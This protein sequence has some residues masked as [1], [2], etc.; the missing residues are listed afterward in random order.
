MKLVNR[1]NKNLRKD[2]IK[3]RNCPSIDQVLINKA[4]RAIKTF[5]RIRKNFLSSRRHYFSLILS[6]IQI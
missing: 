5:G 2:C 3:A 4:M 1:I 6:I